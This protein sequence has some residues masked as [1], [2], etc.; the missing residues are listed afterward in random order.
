M[1][2]I[3]NLLSGFPPKLPAFAALMTGCLAALGHAPWSLWPLAMLGFIGICAFQLRASNAGNAA[4]CGW[5]SGLGYFGIS[6]F[7]I[8]EPFLV[9]IA[10]HGWMAPFA[11]FFM[12]A[13]LA[14]FWALPAAISARIPGLFLRSITFVVTLTIFEMLRSIIFTGFPWALPAYIWSEHP[15]LQLSAW[16]GPFG[17]SLITLLISSLSAFAH[18]HR[19]IAIACLP[20]ALLA[21]SWIAAEGRLA[22]GISETTGKTARLLQPNAAQHLKWQRDMI[23][24]FFNKQLDM[25]RTANADGIDLIVWPEMA[26]GYRLNQTPEALELIAAAANGVPTAFGG[27]SVVDEKFRNT[28]AVMNAQ[29]EVSD[30]YYKHHL[31]PFGEYVPLGDLLGDIGIRGLAAGDGAG[32]DVG[33]GPQVIEINGVGKIL[34]LICYELIFPRHLRTQSRPDIILQVTNDAW[35]GNI[36]GPYQHLAQA[37]FRAVEQGLPVLRSAN[38]GISAAIDPYGRILDQ[39]ALNEE[40]YLDVAIPAPLAPTLY[41]RTGDTPLFILL[42]VV[43]A[44][45]VGR[46]ALGRRHV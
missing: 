38:T 21:G 19:S 26:V 29:G 23:P 43:T 2:K 46:A 3:K 36:S 34:P 14:L 8:V 5:L 40:G 4:W 16:I 10:R 28:L 37:K 1:P 42:C 20:V 27:N 44:G 24:V 39:L 31:V 22:Q 30:W 7:W 15:M 41:S 17:L 11:L 33:D 25:S 32:Y 9:D 35:F 18:L 13:G 6:L 12:A 45:I